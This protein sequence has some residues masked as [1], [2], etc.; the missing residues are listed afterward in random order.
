MRAT[1]TLSFP[2]DLL[3][4]LKKTAKR[5]GLS[6]S[7]YVQKMFSFQRNLISEEELLEDIRIGKYEAERGDTIPLGTDED[8]EKFFRAIQ[9]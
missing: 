9:T 5:A 4:E 8:I 3:K 7:T 1:V 6:V 2:A